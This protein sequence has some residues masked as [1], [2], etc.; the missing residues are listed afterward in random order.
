MKIDAEHFFTEYRQKFGSLNQSQVDGLN[1]LLSQ[2]ESDTS[3]RDV[4]HVAYLLA[5]I[6]HECASQWKP[7]TEYGKRDYFAK[8]EPSTSIG[9]RLGNTEEGD[10]FTYR[11]RGYVQT[12]GRRNHQ[13]LTEVWNAA[14]PEDKRDFVTNPEQLLDPRIS[15]FAAAEGMRI[16]FY[17]G[18]KL[19]DYINKTKCDYAGARAII[20]GK[21]RAEL[22]ASYAIKFEKILQ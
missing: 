20:N 18:R 5:T 13:R 1:A 17:T 2:I 21:D 12:T 10:G 8:Y 7:I 4:R 9:K 11:G 16:G 15:Y 6:R 22:I 19:D 14:H 3:W